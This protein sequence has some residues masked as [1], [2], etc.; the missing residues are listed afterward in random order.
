MEPLFYEALNTPVD[1][2]AEDWRR[3]GL[4]FLNGG[5]FERQ[6]GDVSLDLRRRPVLG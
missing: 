4:P 3:D 2:R 5:L 6:Y 1:A